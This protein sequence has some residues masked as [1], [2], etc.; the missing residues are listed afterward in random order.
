MQARQVNDCIS[1]GKN[2][3][4]V[5]TPEGRVVCTGSMTSG[6]CDVPVDLENVIAVSCGAWHTVALTREGNVVCWG[7]NLDG[8]CNTPPFLETAIAIS[9]GGSFTAA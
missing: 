9:G 6:K 4:A 5:V 3:A 1:I 8:Q 7:F 2:H